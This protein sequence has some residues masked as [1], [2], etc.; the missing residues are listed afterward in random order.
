MRLDSLLASPAGV[1]RDVALETLLAPAVAAGASR[2]SVSCVRAHC[3]ATSSNRNVRR[4][5]VVLCLRAGHDVGA[6]AA[7]LVKL[8]AATARSLAVTE[9][10]VFFEHFH[11]EQAVIA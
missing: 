4:G 1:P 10:R 7:G 11:A 3:A 5:A 9:R 6:A 2:V 8:A